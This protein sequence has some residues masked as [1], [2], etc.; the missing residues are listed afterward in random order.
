MAKKLLFCLF[1][2]SIQ[3]FTFASNPWHTQFCDAPAP[4]NFE[5]TSMT[6]DLVTL[7]WD[8][9][10]AGATH[11]LEL[12]IEENGAWVSLW[13]NP[14]V[15]GGAI[16]LDNLEPGSYLARLA[17]N[18]ETGEASI[19]IIELTFEF[20]IIDLVVVGRTPKNPEVV[21]DCSQI[22]YWKHEWVGFRITESGTEN[23]SLF[24]VVIEN[25]NPIEQ[26]LVKRVYDNGIVASNELGIYPTN[27]SQKIQTENP[28]RIDDLLKVDKLVGY[29][30]LTRNFPPPAPLSINLCNVLG[31]INLPWKNQYIFQALVAEDVIEDFPNDGVNVE[32]SVEFENNNNVIVENPVRD[33]FNITIPKTNLV[34][35]LIKIRL[36]DL[37]SNE[38]LNRSFNRVSGQFYMSA[39]D[40]PQGIYFME[41]KSS[42]ESKIVKLIKI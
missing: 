11:T 33:V 15:P 20:K 19:K 37:Q 29:V 2:A 28:F 13:V 14:E 24:E 26:V 35:D 34:N 10:V 41:I 36:F 3:S 8:P 32:K 42:S 39:N 22:L 30:S 18:C 25:N 38:I 27:V 7:G 12:M 31:N 16:V 21:Q 1:F 4:T 6:S 40:I 23:S 17:T 9:S 5:V